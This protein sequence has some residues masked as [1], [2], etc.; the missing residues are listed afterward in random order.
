[1]AEKEKK[2]L[3]EKKEES[4]KSGKQVAQL[5]MQN[6]QSIP[7]LIVKAGPEEDPEIIAAAAAHGMTVTS[8]IKQASEIGLT[9]RASLGLEDAPV[10]EVALQY[11]PNG[12]LVEPA[13]EE[14]LA[15]QMRNLLR[16]YKNFIKNNAGKE[17]IYAQVRE[18]HHFKPYSVQVHMSEL[19]QLFNLRDLDKS[20]L[21]CYVL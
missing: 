1:M 21:S 12:P 19:F 11:V 10:S 14:S 4:K 16:W 2:A 3:E 15:P 18:E 8:A 9:L 17:Y 7:P 20:I 13:Q 5:G 6:K